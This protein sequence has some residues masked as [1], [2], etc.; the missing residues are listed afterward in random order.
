MSVHITYLHKMAK[1]VTKTNQLSIQNRKYVLFSYFLLNMLMKHVCLTPNYQKWIQC[2]QKYPYMLLIHIKWSNQPPKRTNQLS[3]LSKMWSTMAYYGAL[4]C[5]TAHYVA[6]QRTIAHKH[7]LWCTNR[8]YS[9]Q[10]CT[11]AHKYALW[12][13]NMHYGAQ[14][15]TTLH[16]HALRRTNTH[17]DAQQCTLAHY[18][19]LRHIMG[20][21]RVL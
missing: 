9:A 1:L 13:T 5:T 2:T 12:R 6:L 20:Y 14:T 18:D 8:H 19:A 15:H 11:T 3:N 16:K 4:Q 21:Y 7:A 10:T 17:Y